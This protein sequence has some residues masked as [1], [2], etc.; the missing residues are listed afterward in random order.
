MI[1][2]F[3]RAVYDQVVAA[4]RHLHRHSGIKQPLKTDPVQHKMK[5]KLNALQQ[6]DDPR[7]DTPKDAKAIRKVETLAFGRK[8]EANLVDQLIP[9]PDFTS[10]AGSGE[11]D[12]EDY[13]SFVADGDFRVCKGACFSTP[14]SCV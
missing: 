9:A 7:F 1:V 12:G 10:L 13:W 8:A 14:C 2:P 3:K 6:T 5:R 4:F 11:C